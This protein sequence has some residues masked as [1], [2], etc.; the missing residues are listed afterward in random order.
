M[1]LKEDRLAKEHGVLLFL[2]CLDLGNEQSPRKLHI[3]AGTHMKRSTRSF[4]LIEGYAPAGIDSLQP[5]KGQHV[6]IQFGNTASGIFFN[7][8]LNDPHFTYTF[9]N[10]E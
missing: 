3:K 7:L 10:A 2:C 8:D 9:D 6:E 4:I 5:L 1:R